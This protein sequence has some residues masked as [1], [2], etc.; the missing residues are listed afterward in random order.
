LH[1][2]TPFEITEVV[3]LIAHNVPHVRQL[4]V[5]IDTNRWCDPKGYPRLREAAVFPDWLYDESR[6]NDLP[7]V[8]N[9]KT[10]EAAYEQLEVELGFEPP[11][12]PPDGYRNELLDS[13]WNAAK[14]R[15]KIYGS[16]GIAVA[17]LDPY[18]P[19]GLDVPAVPGRAFPDIQLLRA[20]TAALPATAEVIL[21]VM[22]SHVAALLDD[23][24]DERAVIEQ[25]KGSLA[26]EIGFPRVSVI[27]FRIPSIWT[28]NDDNYW[29]RGHFR[30]GLAHDLVLRIKEAVER[31]RD[32][33]DGV[34]RYL[35]GPT[36]SMLR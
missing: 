13:K 23:D 21:V 25:C 27:D 18:A 34:Y 3:R 16:K 36:A 12:L 32:A 7:S 6:V 9:L 33:E 4:I 28:R 35:A 24:A 14:A 15:K 31:R 30:V 11:R 8:F 1:G 17:A 10:V 22:P 5:G 26:N 2:G 29:D 19:D 20:A